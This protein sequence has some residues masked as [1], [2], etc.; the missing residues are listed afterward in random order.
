MKISGLTPFTTIDYPGRISCVLYSPG[1]PWRCRYCQNAHLHSFNPQPDTQIPM[2]TVFDFL[3]SRQ[4]LL[5]AVVFSGGEPTAYCDLP[6]IAKHVR[7]LG[8]KTGLHTA[9]PYPERLELALPFFD[10]VGFDIKAPF[11]DRYERVTG[12]K[13]SFR[14]AYQ[15]LL[16]LLASGKPHQFRTTVHP[17]L[18]SPE[19]LENLDSFLFGLTGEKT[20]R[21]NFSPRGCIDNELTEGYPSL[22]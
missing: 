4:G 3:R 1:C 6:A 22:H 20:V 14:P 13:D 5:E 8:F 18:L 16:V 17:K 12:V 7:D 11:D 10:W 2:D 19:D 15:S 21:Q 9:G